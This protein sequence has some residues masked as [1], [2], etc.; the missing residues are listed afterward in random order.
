MKIGIIGYGKMGKAVETQ[1]LKRGHTVYRL[2]LPHPADSENFAIIDCVI[3]FSHADVAPGAISECLKAGKHVV[4][5]TTGWND[6]L[7]V[8]QNLCSEHD[9]A[10]CWAPNFSLGMHIMFYVNGLLADVMN[11]FEAYTPNLL[12]IHHTEKK[13]T[14]S[15]TAIAIAEQVVDRIDRTNKWKL[16]SDELEEQDTLIID[17]RREEDVKGIH[18]ITYQ[19][20]Q[21]TISLRH[22]ALSRE[23][24]ALG[25]VIA[26]EWMDGKKGIFT[27]E[28]ILDF[29]TKS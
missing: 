19:S 18:R 3:D 6:Q 25:A 24:F 27:F 5:G 21:D 8:A 26:A 12:E 20:D 9:S 1:A 11:K 15:G 16:K 28:D 10:F 13:D 22:H 17:A 4:S 23:G 7:E 14:P 2:P 29:N